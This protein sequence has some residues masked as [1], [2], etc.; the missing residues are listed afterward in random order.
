[1]M[2]RLHGDAKWVVL[3]FVMC[4]ASVSA[5]RGAAPGPPPTPKAAA[6]IDITGN[7]VSVVTEDWRWRMLTPKKGDT[8]SIPISAEG[9]K[10]ADAWDP[11]KAAADGC[12][13]YGAAAI[14]RVPGRL[15]ISWQDDNTLK[16]E[17][18]AGQQTRLLY[19]NAKDSK[20][21]PV[22][23]WQG[24]SAAEWEKIPQPGGLGVSLQQAPPRIGTLKV[25]TKNLRAGYLRKNGVPY[26]E[27]SVVTEYFDRFSAY[28]AEWLTVLTAVDDSKYLTQQFLTST[29]F[30]REA[31]AS[32]WDP[33]PCE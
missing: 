21:V 26:S 10:L 1:M 19:F 32:K 9:K 27:D 22:P 30:K 23:T 5:Q 11:A 3:L 33:H 28:G 14:M 15:R 16:I 17:T 2:T 6:P 25:I 20:V 31:D 18:D 7:W 13:P 8:S 4:A 24:L 12:K 29:H